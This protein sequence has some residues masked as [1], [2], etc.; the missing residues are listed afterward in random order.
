MTRSRMTYLAVVGAALLLVCMLAGMP[1]CAED[2]NAAPA[3]VTS[4]SADST[5]AP[6]QPADEATPPAKEK[7]RLILM[8]AFNSYF[9]S[10]SQ[11]QKRFGSSWPSIGLSLAYKTKN[12]DPR[13]IELRL[14]GMAENSKLTSA[15]IFP[16]GLGFNTILSSSNNLTTYAGLTGNL[17]IAKIKS[18]PEAVNTGWQF[19]AGAGALVGANIGKKLNVQ[20]SYYMIP[21][22]GGFKMSGFNVSAHIQ[23][24]QF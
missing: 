3:A 21:S 18:L 15:Y 24:W 19:K 23:L 22:L 5:T 16:V 12:M 1:A 11:T 10:D 14:D 6:A 7:R 17:Y 2:A 8:P 20:G 4:T 9:P 13:K